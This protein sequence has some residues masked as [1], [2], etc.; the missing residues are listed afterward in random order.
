MTDSEIEDLLRRH[1][2]PGPP[3]RLRAR[4]VGVSAHRRIWPWMSAAA[5]LLVSAL[6]RHS[7]AR[8]EATAADMKLEAA[9]AVRVADDLTDILGGDAAARRFAELLVAE[10]DIRSEAHP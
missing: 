6:A 9:P 5:A 1:R 8:S 7:A 10:Q 2:P 4:I 3:A